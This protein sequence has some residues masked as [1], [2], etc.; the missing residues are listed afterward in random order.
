MLVP[1]ELLQLENPVIVAPENCAAV[2]VKLVPATLELRGTA[3]FSPLHMV[4]GAAEPTGPLVTTTETVSLQLFA[5][6]QTNL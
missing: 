6:F 3:P 2:Q 4:T 5:S 1:Q